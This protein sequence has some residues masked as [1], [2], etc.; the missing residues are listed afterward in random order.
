LR[1]SFEVS[2]SES[3]NSL[4]RAEMRNDRCTDNWEIVMNHKVTQCH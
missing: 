3:S 4:V 1:D 2:A